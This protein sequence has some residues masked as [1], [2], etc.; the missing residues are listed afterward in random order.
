MPGIFAWAVVAGMAMMQSGLS[1][2]QA[3]GMNVIVFAGSAQLA[4]LPLIAAGAPP[5]LVFLTALVV[6]LRF[7]IFAAGI[8]PHFRHLPW[9]TRLWYGYLNG[10]IV[11]GYFPR[12]YAGTEGGN[13]AGKAGYYLGLCMSNW[14]VWHF[15]SI[16]GMLL[17]SRI[18]AS[19]GISFAGTLAL[20]A[21]LIPLVKNAA[22]LTGVVAAGMV[23]VAGAGLPYRLG[24]LGGVIAG[25]AAA[26][27]VDA[28]R[29][30]EV[31]E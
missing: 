4:S 21:L 13:P 17:A 7:V 26:L 14:L 16:A 19:W 31:A 25:M 3:L 2:W 9:K 18:P 1:L 11:M 22:A 23:A 30:G 12:R 6:N 8:A 15:G 27:A 20:L 10:D 5:M 24:L 28:L 29:G